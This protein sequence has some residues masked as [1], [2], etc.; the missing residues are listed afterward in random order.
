MEGFLISYIHDKRPVASCQLT[1]LIYWW[2]SG[3]SDSVSLSLLS[4]VKKQPISS[5]FFSK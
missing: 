1:C 5:C 4:D 2:L 3:D